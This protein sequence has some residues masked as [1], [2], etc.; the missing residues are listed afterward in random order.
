MG[1]ARCRAAAGFTYIGALVIVTVMG[2]MLGIVGQSWQT[3]MK[4][5]REEELIWRGM[6]Y[7]NAIEKWYKPAAGQ[8]VSTPLQDLKHLVKDPRSLSTVRYLRRL[9][10]DP[11]T[12]KEWQVIKDPNRG[13]VGVASTSE[14]KPL[15]R[16]NF[17]EAL[18]EFEGKSKYSEW[19]FVYKFQQPGQPG[20]P[21]SPTVTGAPPTSGSPVSTPQ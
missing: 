14:A 8:H 21:T 5:E 15:K 9:Y 7:L 12:D 6:Q 16:G 11:V 10:P 13:I 20:R 3:I 1:P 19:Q 18:K 4:R 17:P 2:I